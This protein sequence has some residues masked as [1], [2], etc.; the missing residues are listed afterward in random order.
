MLTGRI[1]KA[2][3]TLQN[4]VVAI[5]NGTAISCTEAGDGSW[6]YLTLQIAGISGD[7][8]TW[9]A[10]VNG[11]NWIAV[12]VTNLNTGNAATTATAD[13]LYRMLVRGLTSFRAR[14]STYSAGT[15]TVTGI[16]TG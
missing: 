15:I 7:T 9:E 14:V 8:I 16:A 6:E 13:G 11:S 3:L 2:G 10:T 12:A 4:A 1:Y 5:G